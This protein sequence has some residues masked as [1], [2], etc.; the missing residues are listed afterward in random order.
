MKNYDFNHDNSK[1]S[2]LLQK[3]GYPY[4]Y[5]DAWEKFNEISLPGKEGFYNHLNIKDNT[6]AKRVCK[7]RILGKNIMICMFKATHYC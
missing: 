6:D 2:L 5:M 7:K 4:E 3:G 1:F